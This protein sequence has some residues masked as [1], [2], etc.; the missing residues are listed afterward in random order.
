M[1]E[2]ILGTYGLLCWL[3]FKKFKVVPVNTYTIFTAI[4]GGVV[5]LLILFVLLSVFHPASHD[6]RMYSVVVQITPNVRGLV[7]E[8]PVE[9]NKPLKT[10]D[11]LFRIDP[12]P[13][14]IEV[15]RLRAALAGKNVEFAQLG[16]QM[17]A[18]EAATR[19]ARASLLVSESEFDR[20]ARENYE[21]AESQVQQ[22]KERRDLAKV[23]LDRSTKLA[24]TGAGTQIELDRDTA[25][26]A[27]ANE[28]LAQAEASAR[29]ASEKLK[30]GSSSLES[31][32]EQVARAEAAE[33]QVRLQLHA[34][35]DG[36]NP[37]VRE[38]MAQ[39]DFKRWE[40]DQTVVRA[41]CNGYVPTVV[42]RPGQ[43]AVPMPLKPLMMF[44]VGEQPSLVASFPQKVISE[45]KPGLDAEAA[46][47]AYPGRS[48]KIK[49]RRLLTAVSEGE[50]N[51]SG[52]LLTTTSAS[53]KGHIPVVFD[54][55]ED[56]AALQLPIGAQA[57][58]AIYTERV[59]ALSIVR[60][61]ILRMKSWENY[62]F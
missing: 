46:F 14:Q 22:V 29:I 13:Y 23:E 8:V 33:R 4:L 47:K 60:K 10:G 32:R 52:E 40:L 5:I 53:A 30:T 12:R 34:K 19:Q 48:F 55:G 41:P 28:E 36:V 38:M 54:Y 43:M 59:H 1:I 6:G 25:R 24:E 18:A 16:E 57:S 17:A 61:I 35:E 56:V 50:L 39:L 62:L 42:L 37:E 3:L 44:I 31:V 45:I 2:L 51:A 9:P 27:S 58:I 11:V 49:V 15:D 7:V 20:Q 26:L 21:R